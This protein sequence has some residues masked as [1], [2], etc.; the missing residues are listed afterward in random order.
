MLYTVTHLNLWE[1][2]KENSSISFFI[3]IG[4][5]L[6]YIILTNICSMDE[7]YPLSEP[8]SCSTC[9][10]RVFHSLQALLP[11]LS[12]SLQLFAYHHRFLQGCGTRVTGICHILNQ[13][14]HSGIMSNKYT[15]AQAHNS[16]ESYVLGIWLR[17]KCT[18]DQGGQTRH[19][20]RYD[21][22]FQ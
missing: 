4:L 17:L 16:R 6:A 11:L 15:K 13:N 8:E 12:T 14:K 18:F 3:S 9:S 10:H 22:K 21:K 19:Y 2:K 5:F 7:V 1:A 20:G